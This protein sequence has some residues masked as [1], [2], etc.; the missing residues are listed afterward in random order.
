MVRRITFSPNEVIPA[1]HRRPGLVL[2]CDGIVTPD[3]TSLKGDGAA[4]AAGEPSMF[5]GATGKHCRLK[6]FIVGR[7]ADMSRFQRKAEAQ[8]HEANEPELP[9]GGHDQ[10]IMRDERGQEQPRDR[11]RA[12]RV[13]RV[14][15][16]GDPPGKPA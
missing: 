1:I 9:P 15:R 16:G 13:S 14:D 5:Q 4:G 8:P 10:G 3:G 11:E 12:Q 6:P 7:R 2:L